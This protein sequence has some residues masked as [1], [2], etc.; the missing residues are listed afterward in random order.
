MTRQIDELI[1]A[2]RT[3]EE[4]LQEEFRRKREEFRFTIEERRVRFAEELILQHRRLKVGLL[5]YLRE[6][7][8]PF[9]LT[10]PVIYAGIVP[11]LF[12]DLFI[13]LYQAICFP[14][15]G[16]P[17]ARRGDYLVFD[18]EDLPYLN[19]LEK[20]NCA[21]CSYANGLAAWF[22]E[23]AARTEQY[24]CPIKHARR[25]RDAHSRYPRFF[26]YGDAE[27]YRKGL[28]RLQ[29]EYKEKS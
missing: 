6:A 25:I 9:V 4:E 16:I 10:A 28:E 18:R 29:K 3:L 23:V 14:V 24:W 20:I 11:L 1:E 19:A 2:I 8:L 26:E 7:R 21:Y 22:R 12:L 5:R 13:S 15:Y 17:K 27:S